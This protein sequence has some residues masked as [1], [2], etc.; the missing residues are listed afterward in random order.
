MK[1]AKISNNNFLKLSNKIAR[2]DGI[3]AAYLFGSYATNRA[4]EKSDIDIGILYENSEKINIVRNVL[5]VTQDI[6]KTDNIDLCLLNSAS[7][8]MAFEIISGKRIVK[9]DIDKT[10][11]FESLVMREYEDENAR[12]QH[13]RK[14]K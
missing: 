7:P 11:E 12:L 6:L 3:I 13:C 8:I 4:T 2:I 10:A 5:S 9:N 1:S 14:R